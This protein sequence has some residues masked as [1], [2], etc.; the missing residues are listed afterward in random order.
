MASEV[1]QV[2]VET[3]QAALVHQI[4]NIQMAEDKT[5]GPEGVWWH[6]NGYYRISIVT[7]IVTDG[8]RWLQY[9]ALENCDDTY[10]SYKSKRFGKDPLEAMKGG[11]YEHNQMMVM[12]QSRF[13]STFVPEEPKEIKEIKPT[14]VGMHNVE[15]IFIPFGQQE[16]GVKKTAKK[17]QTIE[18]AQ[19]SLSAQTKLDMGN[20]L[21][22]AGEHLSS[23]HAPPPQ[24]IEVP[25]EV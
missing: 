3:P 22:L 20:A 16:A 8:R 7:T 14:L 17:R 4:L 15:Q 5:K 13:L 9:F 19:N 11:F 24:I 10:K 21:L 1:P 12:E 18:E 23:M 6:K 25:N 2:V